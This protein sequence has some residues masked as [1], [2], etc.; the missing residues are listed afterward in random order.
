MK[1]K[2]CMLT[3]YVLIL[4]LISVHGFACNISFSLM[5]QNGKAAHMYPGGVTET[6]DI[7]LPIILRSWELGSW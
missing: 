2:V 6:H 7:Y 5:D 3:L 1:A 4:L